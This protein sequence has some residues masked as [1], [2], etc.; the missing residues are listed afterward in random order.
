MSRC[1]FQSH[2]LEDTQSLART[3]ALHAQGGLT[4]ALDGE[5]GAGKTQFVRSFCIARGVNSSEVNSPTFVLLQ[6]YQGTDLLIA[7]MDAYRLESLDEFLAIGGDEVLQDQESVCLI[8]WAEKIREALPTDHLAVRITQCSETGREFEFT[9][10]H[11]VG[12]VVLRQL[13]DSHSELRVK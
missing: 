7:H 5:L 12:D 11:G 4:I 2:G 8:E 9:A 6:Y 1:V 3:V 13:A 10:E